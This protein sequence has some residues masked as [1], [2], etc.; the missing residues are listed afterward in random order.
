MGNVCVCAR[1]SRKMTQTKSEN[2][3]MVM[4]VQSI[5]ANG[6]WGSLT[7]Y[8]NGKRCYQ[9]HKRIATAIEYMHANDRKRI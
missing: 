5:E 4:T 2:E 7:P 8:K 6:S 3:A 1:I 9:L